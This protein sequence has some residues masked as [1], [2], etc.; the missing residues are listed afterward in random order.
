MSFRVAIKYKHY[1]TYI[2]LFQ[3]VP[4]QFVMTTT[5][6]LF[7]CDCRHEDFL[8]GESTLLGSRMPASLGPF[9]T[10]A[11]VLGGDSLQFC[12]C[13]VFSNCWRPLNGVEI[14]VCWVCH[15]Y[16]SKKLGVKTKKRIGFHQAP[17]LTPPFYS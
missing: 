13:F 17:S 16:A 9:T 15:G 2:K 3:P 11:D 8:D 14:W 6:P 12:R 1:Q 5:F 4:N 10:S 7:S